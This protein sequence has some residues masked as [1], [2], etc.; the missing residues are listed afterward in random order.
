MVDG[1]NY[2]RFFA[3]MLCVISGT[4]Y[5]KNFRAQAQKAKKIAKQAKQQVAT[6]IDITEKVQQSEQKTV[7]GL[8]KNVEEKKPEQEPIFFRQEV[9]KLEQEFPI[10][11]KKQ[12]EVAVIDEKS[13]EP[14]DPL[15]DKQDPG[16]FDTHD[17][18]EEE[19]L[20]EFNFEN[21]DL[22]NIIKQVEDIFEVTFICDDMIQPPAQIA[23]APAPRALKGNIVSF[24]TNQ[25]LTR[26]KA[27][28]LFVTFAYLAGFAVVEHSLP[29]MYRIAPIDGAMKMPLKAYIGV[30]YLELPDNDEL[31]RYVYFVDNTSLNSISEFVN[32]VRTPS[33]S[34]IQL[35]EHKAFVLTDKASNIRAIMAIVK[36]LDKVTMPEV[37][38]VMQL[39]EVNA[40]EIEKLF[41]TIVGAPEPT[42]GANMF[43]ARKSSTT[44][45]FPEGTRI[46]TYKQGNKLILL[47]QKDK[48]KQ[49]EE[50]VLKYLDVVPSQPYSPFFIYPLRYADAATVADIMNDV[51]KFGSGTAAGMSGGIRGK[52]QYMRPLAFIPEPESNRLIVRGHYQDFEKAKEVLAK[53]DE[54]QPQVGIEVLI[55][56]LDLTNTKGMGTQMRNKAPNG[57]NGLLGNN[58]KFQTSGL[59]GIS[60][61]VQNVAAAAG[62][63]RLLGNILNLVQGATPGT[64]M[65]AL[66]S[67][68]FGV[69][70]VFQVLEQITNTQ[71]VANP[72]L[73]A[74][75]K[76]PAK[77]Y[78]GEER[79]VLTAQVVGT[80]IQNA[81]GA[82]QA[83]LEV[84]IIPQINSDGM[85]VLDV[86]ITDDDY[87]DP[88]T[89]IEEK[90]TLRLV[91]THAVVADKQVLAIGGLMKN[92]IVTTQSKV[93]ILG[94]IP[95][96]GN[97]FKNTQKA[98]EKHDLLIL[99]S[100]HIIEPH[101][102]RAI[103]EFTDKHVGEYQNSLSDMSQ[104]DRSR[105]P[106]DRMFFKT[107]I[108]DTERLVEDFIFQRREEVTP[109]EEGRKKNRS[110]FA[111]LNKGK[112]TQETQQL[113]EP[114]QAQ[115][116]IVS[117][118]K[119]VEQ[120]AV[121]Q[122]KTEQDR[123]SQDSLFDSIKKRER[124]TTSLSQLLA[125]SNNK[126]E[127]KA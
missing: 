22:V 74:T 101:Q 8:K 12:N 90:K 2:M 10:E 97:L 6:Q 62:V 36:E 68:L 107:K 32:G 125:S 91:K 113:K 118:A 100:S 26:Q 104:L 16:F 44:R 20:V 48:V 52:D 96:L 114:S 25:P 5:A 84:K 7:D 27:W 47:G 105:D 14:F 28:D 17:E 63:D 61:I 15:R 123:S 102:D 89:D 1:R 51:T 11:Q 120:K 106:V 122:A 76:V 9:K 67:D 117:A 99:I 33:S 41:T 46:I 81:Y 70:G 35:Q 18:Q 40:E 110:R 103:R 3:L 93:P 65:L 116:Q 39:K 56:H 108:H 87:I 38:E 49:I 80:S 66:G 86:E 21:V 54:A 34:F 88:A 50:F 82:D 72:F 77:V 29:H 73:I 19:E 71:V 115:V 60:G 124:S 23:G 92:K 43:G 85:I 30:D 57:P 121:E 55:L 4:C 126:T 53:L 58:V 79:R 98:V 24:K 112:T 119:T 45:L 95:I 83:K 37:V 59:Y 64:T 78:L 127:V 111:K 13:Q 75:N 69:W 109:Q 31:I 94:D 42:V